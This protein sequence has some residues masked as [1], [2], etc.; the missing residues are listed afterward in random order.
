MPSRQ[1]LHLH[2]AGRK[3]LLGLLQ[4]HP[5]PTVAEMAGLCGYDFL[6]VD[7]EHGVFSDADCLDTFR[8]LVATDTLALMR[9]A[10]HD[11]QAVGRYLDLGA[12]AIVVPN[13]ATAEQATVLARAMEYPPAGTRGMGASLHRVTQYG[14]EAAEYVKAPRA[15]ASLLPIIESAL[16][17]ANVEEILSVEGVDGVIIGPADLSADLGCAGDF[18]TAAFAQAVE[19]I[20]RTVRTSGKL[21][22]TAPYPGSPIEALLARGHRLLILGSDVSLLR[23]AMVAQLVM[24]KSFL[25]GG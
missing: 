7:G 18:S 3:A 25:E 8:A 10:G 5:G 9:L 22:G 11:G 14:L 23:E 1:S 13:V 24:A 19:R 15:R 2:L 17:A 4:S 12:D 6:F 20:E 16:G 21:L